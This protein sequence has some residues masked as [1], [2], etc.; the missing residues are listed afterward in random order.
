VER[1]RAGFR[2][3]RFRAFAVARVVP[4]IQESR[5]T[6]ARNRP[7][8]V[9]MSRLLESRGQVARES[10]WMDM[11]CGRSQSPTSLRRESMKGARGGAECVCHRS[12]RWGLAEVIPRWARKPSGDRSPTPIR[13][14]E[15]IHRRPWSILD[16]R[17]SSPHHR[18]WPS[19]TQS[20]RPRL[21]APP[22]ASAPSTHGP[23]GRSVHPPA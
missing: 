6:A 23:G 7:R 21:D 1:R 13:R 5:Q 22:Q 12:G 9:G 20:L 14:G 2:D 4:S 8:S 17:S 10:T 11:K 16:P 19:G 3:V 18:G 15:S